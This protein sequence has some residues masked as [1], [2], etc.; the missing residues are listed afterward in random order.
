MVR[1]RDSVD[2][3]PKARS[4]IPNPKSHIPHPTSPTQTPTKSHDLGGDSKGRS[5]EPNPES[6]IPTQQFPHGKGISDCTRFRRVFTAINPNPKSQIPRRANCS[7]HAKNPSPNAR[8]LPCPKSC[9]LCWLLLAN[10]RLANLK[11]QIPA[12]R[13][14][15]GFSE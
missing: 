5:Q 14:A 9:L 15:L 11:P 1:V 8:D 4:Q 6:Q 13:S 3:Y 12:A 2:Q 10:H 7:Q